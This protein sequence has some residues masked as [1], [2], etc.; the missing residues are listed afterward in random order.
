MSVTLPLNEM[1]LSEKLQVMEAL[2]EDL[3]RNSDAFGSPAWHETVLE[4]REKKIAAGE[5]HFTD[6]EKAKAD[7]RNR[8]S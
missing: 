2:W 6:W 3:S 1:S 5:A 4:E 7:I 8:V